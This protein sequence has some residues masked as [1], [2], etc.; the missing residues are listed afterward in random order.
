MISQNKYLNLFLISNA[1][2]IIDQFTKFLVTLHIPKNYSVGVILDF[3]QFTHIRNAG[4]AFGLFANSDV[5]YKVM[6]FIVFSSIAI[7][8]IL[9]FYH[10]TTNDQKMVQLG[11]ILLFSGA[12]GNLIDRVLHHEVIDFLDFYYKN[13]HWPAFNIADSCITIG[14]V[15]VLIDQFLNGETPASKE[16]SPSI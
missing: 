10:Q 8:A 4:V 5:E 12:I 1:L 11:L 14:V 15:L 6:F 7:I 13:Y 16:S 3:F 2:I 9:V